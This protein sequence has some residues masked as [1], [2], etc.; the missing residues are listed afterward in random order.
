MR[1]KPVSGRRCKDPRT[2]E[3]VPERGVTVPKNSYWLKR[4]KDGDCVLMDSEPSPEPMKEKPTLDM[5]A[6]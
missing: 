3:L 2:R 1:I 5:E 4:L 6:E